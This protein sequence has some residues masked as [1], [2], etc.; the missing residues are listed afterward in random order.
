M[1]TSVLEVTFSTST[2][3][4]TDFK[5]VQKTFEKP[6]QQPLKYSEAVYFWRTSASIKISACTQGALHRK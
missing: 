6:G 4:M 5:G 2:L 1:L 3:L